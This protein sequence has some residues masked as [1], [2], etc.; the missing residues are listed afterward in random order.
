MSVDFVDQKAHMALLLLEASG[1][2]ICDVLLQSKLVG[3]CPT[4][5]HRPRTQQVHE[6]NLT[7]SFHRDPTQDSSREV[8]WPDKERIVF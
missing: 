3:R 4:R 1:S 8:L 7:R 5:F 2:A 6:T